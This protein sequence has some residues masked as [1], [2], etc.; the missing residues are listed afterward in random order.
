MKRKIKVLYV[1]AEMAP[2]ATAGGLGEVGKS[3]PYAL[4]DTDEIE[5]RR[6]MPL[7]KKVT[8]NMKYVND[9]MVTLG[10]DYETCILRSDPDNNEI[11]TYFIDNARYFHREN[12]Y[13]YEDDGYRFFFFCKAVIEMLKRIP[14]KPDI[15]HTND[16]HTGF[17]PYLIKKELP[18]MKS[19]YSVHNIAYHGYIPSYLVDESMPEEEME[20]LGWPEWLNFMKAG[21]I[22]S[23]RLITVSPGY[24]GEITETKNSYG[25]SSFIE[26]KEFNIKGILN[27]IDIKTYDPLEDG[28]QAYPFQLK[29]IKRKS[30]N[31]TLLRAQYKFEDKDVPLISMITRLDFSKG[32]DLL[33]EIFKGMNLSSFQLII[34]GSGMKEYHELLSEL[35]DKYPETLKVDFNYTP[36]LAKKIYGASD[37]YLM[38]SQ[39]EPCGMG[40]LYAMRY[41]TVPVVNPVGGLKDTVIDIENNPKKSTGFYMERW[42]GIALVSTLKR[43][44]AMYKTQDWNYYVKNCMNYDASWTRSVTEYKKLYEDMLS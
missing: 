30:M 1:A 10:S 4:N 36:D 16:W 19:V 21:I 32:I 22:Y 18:Y 31:K 33:I 24:A 5:I 35:A 13:G 3:L 17:L 6:V 27:G 15:I 7:Y 28:V 26:Q 43:A 23:D 44:I 25:M 2:Y 39:F 29:S 34:L 40:Q 9:F 14:Y 37:I 11:P 42:N 20:Q 38:P 8:G 12:I 41:G